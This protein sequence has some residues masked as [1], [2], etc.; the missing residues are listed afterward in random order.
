MNLEAIRYIYLR[1]VVATV[2]GALGLD[3]TAAIASRLARGVFDMNTAGRKRT[4]ARLREAMDAMATDADIDA[5][6]AAMYQHIGRFWAEALFA[7]RLLRDCSWRHFVRVEGETALRSLVEERRGCL[8]A[9]AYHGNPAVGVCALGQFFRPVHVMVDTFAQPQLRAW[10]HELYSQ[11]WVQPVN[12]KD[13]AV[14]VPRILR[15]GGAVMMICEHERQRG[16]AVPVRFLGRTLNGYPTLG[17]LARWFNVP[18]GVIT[19]RRNNDGRFSFTLALHATIEHA[20]TGPSGNGADADD[21]AVVRQVMAVLERAI[22]TCPEQYYWTLP[23]A[24]PQPGDAKTIAADSLSPTPPPA[25]EVDHHDR[26]VGR[27]DAVDAVGL[28]DAPR[29]DGRELLSGLQAKLS[30]RRE[31]EIVRDT[32]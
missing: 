21:A 16:R 9:T 22:M 11:R 1:R 8:L 26:D 13:A 3:A 27:A 19:C 15:G 10:Q 6:T 4:E 14:A 32:A 20:S 29:A 25:F 28:T 7:R 17:R 23:M 31:I 30:D 2:L 24:V 12:R 5:I 18:V